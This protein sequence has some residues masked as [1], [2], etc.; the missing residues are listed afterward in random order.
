MK[1]LQLLDECDIILNYEVLDFRKWNKGFYR[2]DNA[3]YHKNLKT[4]PNHL[5]TETGIEE[6]KDITFEEILE[7][8]NS[9]IKK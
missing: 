4:F 3:P 7:Y 8:I 1:I 5:H 9:V 6:N 2:W